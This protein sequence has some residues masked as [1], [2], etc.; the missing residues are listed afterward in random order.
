MEH[1][2]Q[3]KNAHTHGEPS[4]TAH[5]GEHIF[6]FFTRPQALFPER[7]DAKL[8][9]VFFVKIDS[10]SSKSSHQQSAAELLQLE[11]SF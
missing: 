9:C 5:W 8:F 4:C 6:V 10:S 3:A 11:L 7:I 1:V 2:A